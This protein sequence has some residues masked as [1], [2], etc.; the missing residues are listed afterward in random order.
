MS[1]CC[2]KGIQWEATPVGNESE[3][4]G[5]R[6]YVTGT[7]SSAA[8]MIIHDLYGW[9]FNNTRL[10]ADHYA[11]EIGATVYLPDFFGG[12]A[13]P[14]D[15]LNDESR[16]AELNLP[17]FLERNSKAVRFPEMEE[18]ARALRTTH[19]RLGA[20][21]FCYGGWAVF[22]LGDKESPLVDCIATAHPTL[23]EEAEIRRVGVPVQILAPEIDPQFTLKL[24][25]FSNQEIPRLGVPYT[26]EFF[27]GLEHGFATRGDPNNHEERA[28]MTRAKNAVVGWMRQ[29]LHED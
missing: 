15:I 26:M 6:C 19:R 16:W 2:L 5:R 17:A 9:T 10:L 28:G 29:W 22:R 24:R 13:L 12:E 4:A 23:L 7:N 21:G 27:P 8:V 11:K 3:L 1:E 20:V 25:T 14:L 18:C